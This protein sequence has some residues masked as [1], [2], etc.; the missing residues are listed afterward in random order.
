[1]RSGFTHFR[2][3]AW[4]ARE[5]KSLAALQGFVVLLGS[6]SNQEIESLK[7][8]CELKVQLTHYL[9]EAC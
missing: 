4:D 2:T 3:Q 1:M 7:K 6:I 8:L 5:Q 9:S